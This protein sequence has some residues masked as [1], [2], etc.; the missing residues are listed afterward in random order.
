MLESVLDNLREVEG[1]QGAMI[2]DA[3]ATIVACSAHAIYDR[4]LLQRVAASLIDVVDAVQLNQE[5]WDL[6]T[7][8]FDDGKLVL[9]NLGIAGAKRQRHVLAVIC[10]ANLNVAFLGVALRVAAV[11][12]V[13]ALDAPPEPAVA[14]TAVASTAVAAAPA[15]S[16]AGRSQISPR[17]SAP[18]GNAGLSW[19][20]VSGGSSVG[21][22]GVAVSELDVFDPVSAAFLSACRR[23]LAASIGPIA[24]VLVKEA[25]RKLCGSRPFSRGDG[26]AL[27]ANLVTQIDDSEGRTRFQRAIQSL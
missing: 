2:V 7:A 15:P 6:L 27:V 5:D 12:L 16:P 11:K 25:V 26:S 3:A 14:S 24:Q 18:P 19:S 4:S 23:A 9:R 1:A 17:A 8:R 10:D 21:A 20:G 22:S 13:A